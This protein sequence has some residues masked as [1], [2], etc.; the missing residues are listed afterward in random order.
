VPV[1]PPGFEVAVYKVIGLPFDAGAIKLTVACVLPGVAVT[2]VGA[3]G[4]AAGITLLEAAD[5]GPGPTALVAVTVKVY[6][7]PF[8]R[9]DTVIGLAVPVPVILPGVEVTVYKVIAVPPFDAGAVKLTVA[10]KL[11]AV[12]ATPVGAP[13]T[14]T[15]IMLFDAADAGPVPT[16]LVA[17]TVNV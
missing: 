11:P 3:S 1:K 15:G 13:G 14:V 16:A 6:D 12:A 2:P 10:S 17:V 7:V 4:N 9:P 8:V 5:A